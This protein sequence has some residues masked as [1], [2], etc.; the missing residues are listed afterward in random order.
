[1]LAL[2]ETWELFVRA[3]FDRVEYTSLLAAFEHGAVEYLAATV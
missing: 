1:M 3:E 2:R